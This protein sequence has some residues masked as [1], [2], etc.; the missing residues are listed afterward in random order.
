MIAMVVV[1]LVAIGITT[2]YFFKLQNDEYHLKRIQRKQKTVNLSLEY[3]LNDL[4]PEEVDDFVSR[5]FDL[6]V[7]EIANVNSLNIHVFNTNGEELINTE[8]RDSV[9]KNGHLNPFLLYKLKSAED[10]K[11]VEKKEN[12]PI[13]SYSYVKNKK[14]ENMVVINIPYNPLN[15]TAKTEVNL[16]LE[17]LLEVFSVLFIGALLIAYLLTR[18]IT[19]SIEEVRKKIEGVE[20]NEAN[21]KLIW[22]KQDEIGVL[23]N[24]Y[25]KM[26]DK[27]EVSKKKLAKNER[28]TA[29][30]EMAKQIA[31][32]IKNPLTPMKLSVQHLRRVMSLKGKDE[33][34]LKQFEDK[35]IG[36]INLLTEIA[37]E[38]S[39]F[40]ELP[41]AKM[42]SIDL[43]VIIRNTISLY[44]HHKHVKIIHDKLNDI[45]I[46]GDENQLTR[47]FNNLLKNSI[48]AVNSN[49]EISISTKVNSI[50]NVILV[51]DNGKGIPIE[52]EDKIFEPKFT[53]KS[54]GKGLGLPIVAQ[55]IRNH[56]G[57]ISLMKKNTKGACF[58]ITLPIFKDESEN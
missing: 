49:G 44:N 7:H 46:F 25:N 4:N 58:R 53:T 56:G 9:F 34:H 16:F 43:S 33:E 3:F 6:K 13:N 52:I 27:L 45:V 17:R 19:K 21:E 51:E 55:I 30:S 15:F 41:K 37:D 42:K 10:G 29:W 32:E 2:V 31:H 20:I 50:H 48:Q 26:I 1:S 22:E 28:Q 35:M 36:Q 54:S 11:Y 14:G 47:V 5:D 38:F 18:Y 12:G 24:A 40:A 57:E 39:N 8:P 23:V